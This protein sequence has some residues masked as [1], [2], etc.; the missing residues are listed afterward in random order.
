VMG[1]ES[2]SWS[3]FLSAR[4]RSI[5]AAIIPERCYSA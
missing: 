4:D 2:P 1:I 5:V 3:N